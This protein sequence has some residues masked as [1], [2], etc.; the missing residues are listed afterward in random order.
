[1]AAVEVAVDDGPWHPTEL[2]AELAPAAWRRWRVR[3]DLPAGRHVVR[4]RVTAATGEVQDERRRPPF[5]SGASGY[6]ELN[7]NVAEDGGRGGA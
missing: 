1:V 6:H 4:S 3:L 5:P 2:A 7:I